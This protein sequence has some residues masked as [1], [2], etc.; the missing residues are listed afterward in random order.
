MTYKWLI[1]LLS[2]I[3]GAS[4]VTSLLYRRGVNRDA[5]DILDLKFSSPIGIG[6]G[7][8]PNGECLKLLSSTGVGFCT[9]GPLS[10]TNI[11]TG[12]SK[13]MSVRRNPK[14][15]TAAAIAS[16]NKSI[17]DEQ[18]TKDFL[19]TFSLAY[20]FA[21][22]FFLDFA[23]NDM[24]PVLARAVI[25]AVL[26]ARATYEEYKPIII[27]TGKNLDTGELESMLNFCRMNGADAIGVWGSRYVE[28]AYQISGG[29][30]PIAGHG[31]IHDAEDARRMLKNGASLIILRD[32]ILRDGLGFP[33]T[34]ISNLK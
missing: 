17:D 19:Y 13:L 30:F 32:E 5:Y 18:I 14:C 4:T 27:D 2:N 8:D 11:R 24:D 6:S 20:D 3:P 29:R 23:T 1:R 22:L 26:E 10:P 25:S 7:I 9:I 28:L 34:I 12:I 21:D 15:L 33:H 31:N 16:N